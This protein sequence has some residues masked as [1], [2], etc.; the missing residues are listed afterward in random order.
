[1]GGAIYDNPLQAIRELVQNAVD[2]C[3]LRDALTRL[4][5]RAVSPTADN[6]ILINYYEPSPDRQFPVIEV[7]DTGTGM[8]QWIITRWFLKVGRS[9]YGSAEFNRFRVDLRKG[10][11]D[12]APV[13]EFGIGFLSTFLLA[14][15]VEVETALWEPLRGDTRKRVLEIHGPSRLIRMTEHDNTGTNRLRGTH[16]RLTLSRGN[17]F[18]KEK[19]PTWELVT[20]YLKRNFVD[21]PYRLHLVRHGKEAGDEVD[22]DPIGVVVPVDSTR[23]EKTIKIAVDD[24][25]SGLEGEILLMPPYSSAEIDRLLAKE[26][27]ARIQDEQFSRHDRDYDP[28]SILMRGGFRIGNVPGLPRTFISAAASSARLRLKW[29]T[30]AERRYPLTNLARTALANTV[31]IETAV[32]RLWLSWLLENLDR[33]PDGFM[34]SFSMSARTLR[35]RSGQWLERFNAY[36]VHQLAANGWY[37]YLK[38]LNKNA[39]IDEWENSNGQSLK[40]YLFSDGCP[41]VLQ[42]LVLP[43]V[44]NLQMGREA[45]FYLTPP[46]KGWQESLKTWHTF[47]TNPVTWGFYVEYID[48][49]QNLL[50]YEYPGSDYLNSRFRARIEEA[51]DAHDIPDLIEGLRTLADS[52]Q[53]RQAELSSR[54]LSLL[55]RA[56]KQVGDLEIGELFDSWKLESFRL[57]A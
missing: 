46:K 57:S 20:T 39:P 16:V 9:Y 27:A 17:P 10:G 48:P 23:R 5:D 51:F 50:Y 35:G 26:S 15:K 6:R 43:K 32:V 45:N 7:C 34:D 56:Q 1:M 28:N 8:D 49:I 12:F 42:D 2:A 25:D 30:R 13:S 37:S 41:N 40:R 33:L 55:I 24:A 22:I 36:Q 11:L 29:Q 47:I 52:K 4:Y 44:C 54:R 18:E 3:K 31:E 38:R 53:K 19:P 14:D 21:L